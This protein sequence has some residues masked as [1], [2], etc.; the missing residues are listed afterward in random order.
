[1]K[2][3]TAQPV[4]GSLTAAELQDILFSILRAVYRFE[5]VE[6]DRFDLTYPQIYLLKLLG[7]RE[8]LSV[9]DIAGEMRLQLF[10]ATRLVNQ[11]ERAEYCE[12][13]RDERDRRSIRVAI[14]PK[15]TAMMRRIE[16]HALATILPHLGTYGG[17]DLTTI[18]GFVKHLDVILGTGSTEGT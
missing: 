16:E 13:R 8:G 14:T 18:I 10:N 5:R 1:M 9:G 7:R 17:K 3:K 12:K 6:V 4:L 2:K 11:L 15:G